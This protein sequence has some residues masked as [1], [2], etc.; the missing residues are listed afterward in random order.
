MRTFLFVT[1]GV[2]I[3]A[4]TAVATPAFAQY[5]YGFYPRYVPPVT[6]PQPVYVPTYVPQPVYFPPPTMQPGSVPSLDPIRH[7]VPVVMDACISDQG[8]PSPGSIH[9]QPA[10]VRLDP[11]GVRLRRVPRAG[12]PRVGT[13]EHAADCWAARNAPTYTV[14]AAIAEFAQS[15]MAGDPSHGTFA[16]R[17]RHRSA[18]LRGA[19]REWR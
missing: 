19:S 10:C 16:E 6:V 15:P 9:A 13:N 11:G 17:N 18:V 3:V 1:A 8:I 5:P 4:A 14:E 7:P 12:A 2:G